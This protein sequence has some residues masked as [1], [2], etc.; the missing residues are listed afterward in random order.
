MHGGEQANQLPQHDIE[1]GTIVIGIISRTIQHQ[2]II[3]QGRH[4]VI[5]PRRDYGP[6]SPQTLAIDFPQQVE[7][8][9]SP[10]PFVRQEGHK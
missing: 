10:A 2:R 8:V 3:R 9:A 6:H 1:H 5:A 4:I 7:F